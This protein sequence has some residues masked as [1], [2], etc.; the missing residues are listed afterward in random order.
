MTCD[1]CASGLLLAALD[2]M[3][4]GAARIV[5]PVA[6]REALL[7]GLVHMSSRMSKACRNCV[8][9]LD[10]VLCVCCLGH[11]RTCIWHLTHQ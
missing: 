5:M 4:A 7:S 9:V 2:S 3:H 10:K 6:R 8:Y 1:A 11:A